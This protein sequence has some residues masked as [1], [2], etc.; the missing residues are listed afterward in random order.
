MLVYNAQLT[1]NP[2]R[3]PLWAIGGNNSFGF[4]QRNVV[5]GSPLIDVTFLNGLKAL[6]QNMRSLPHWM[7]GSLLVVP[8]CV[9]GLWQRRRDATCRPFPTATVEPV[10]AVS[11]SSK[12][13]NG[14]TSQTC[15]SC[16]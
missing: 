1:G 16:P 10:N 4:G 14:A 8:L 13:R 5:A 12:R 2:F 3:F 7:F 11:P 9:Y 6:H 15:S